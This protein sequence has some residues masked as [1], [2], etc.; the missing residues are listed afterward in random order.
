MS[1][2]SCVSIAAAA[3]EGGKEF[4]AVRLK[5]AGPDL[6]M[7]AAYAAGFSMAPIDEVGDDLE[8]ATSEFL[9]AESTSTAVAVVNSAPS[10]RDMIAGSAVQ[11]TGWI[12]QRVPLLGR[13]APA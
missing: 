12:R 11:V 7:A 5:N 3:A 8:A 10:A 2:E 1:W 4:Q 6:L 9:E 13:G